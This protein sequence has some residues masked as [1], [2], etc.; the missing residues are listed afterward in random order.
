MS[1]K[2]AQLSNAE[3]REIAYIVLFS[4]LI[5]LLGLHIG[6][7]ASALQ[8][9]FRVPYYLSVAIMLA[10]E[11][12]IAMKWLVYVSAG[13]AATIFV[14][15]LGIGMLLE[16]MFNGPKGLIEP[17][18]IEQIAP[19]HIM[20]ILILLLSNAV[21]GARD[22]KKKEK[23]AAATPLFQPTATD[24]PTKPLTAS[25]RQATVS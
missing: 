12:A 3:R 23:A 6:F 15:V 7:I 21:Y 13:V 8:T 22:R 4:P 16:L 17:S 11:I 25:A 1:D 5:V 14:V 20:L 2:S 9:R 24:W 19:I 18:N 10:I